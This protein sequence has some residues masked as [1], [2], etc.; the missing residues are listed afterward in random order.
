MTRLEFLKISLLG[1]V[2]FSMTTALGATTF[3]EN[4]LAEEL[5][6]R[7]KPQLYGADYKLRKEV[8]DAFQEMRKAA[9]K[10]G[11]DP[12]IVSSHRTF[13]HQLGIWNRKY[14]DFTANKKMSGPAAVKKIIEYSTMPGTS[15]HHWGTDFDWVDAKAGI[16]KNPLNPKNYQ[17]QGIYAPLKHW[18][19][20]H[21][22]SFGFYEVYT[23]DSNRKGFKYEPWHFTY[24]PLAVDYLTE[25][26]KLDLATLLSQTSLAGKQHVTQEFIRHYLDNHILGINQELIPGKSEYSK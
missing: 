5:L 15:R 23:N 13:D 18:M 12:Y 19:N 2:A 16:V 3:F 17:N 21:S 24:K 11:F 14:N 20:V 7:R 6:G 26:L 4:N 25:F 22:K 8:H 10:D 1:G 9:Q